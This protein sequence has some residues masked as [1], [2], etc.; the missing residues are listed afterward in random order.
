TALANSRV[1]QSERVGLSATILL[2]FGLG[3]RIGPLIASTLMQWLGNS[4]LYGFMSA[5][6]LILFLRLR[7]VHSQQKAETNVTQDYIMATGDLVSSPLAAALDPR[8]DV[9]SVQEQMTPTSSD[10]EDDLG[11]DALEDDDT[12]SEQQ[13]TF[14]FD[15]NPEP[16][17]IEAETNDLEES[18]LDAVKTA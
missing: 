18:D 5:C 12:D 16:T 4:M 8:V 6:T 14:E 10:D 9:E 15:V 1:E 17:F 11:A 7:Y 2:T 3:A 13:L